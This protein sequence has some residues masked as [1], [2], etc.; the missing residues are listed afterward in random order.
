[1][2]ETGGTSY[3]CFWRFSAEALRDRINDA[4][5]KV[6]ITSD[7]SFRRGN[8]V[9]LKANADIAVAGASCVEHVVVVQRTGN[10]VSMQEGRDIW[11]H[12]AMKNAPITCAAEAMDAEDTLFILYTARGSFLRWSLP[13]G[14]P[15]GSY[16]HTME[17]YSDN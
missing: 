13:R 12:E 10:E 1:M 14:R 8:I 5:A 17:N 11:Y 9:P 2:C 4:E 7:G 6:L 3:H 16:P 15:P